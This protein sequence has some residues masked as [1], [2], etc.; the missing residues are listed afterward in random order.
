MK[1]LDP[2]KPVQLRNGRQVRNVCWDFRRIDGSICISGIIACEKYDLSMTW[3][4]NGKRY[5]NSQFDEVD[6]LI[7]VPEQI[8]GWVHIYK[9]G[10]VSAIYSTKELADQTLELERKYQCGEPV[11]CIYINILVGEGLLRHADVGEAVRRLVGVA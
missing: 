7:N 10:S 1:E 5:P 2:T 3:C 11:A 8:E 9:D 6:D 4:A